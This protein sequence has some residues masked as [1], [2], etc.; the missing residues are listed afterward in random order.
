MTAPT[1]TP[2]APVAAPVDALEALRTSLPLS[3]PD[4]HAL[5]TVADAAFAHLAPGCPDAA[6]TS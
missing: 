6:V 2:V 3:D 5:D 1:P 4:R